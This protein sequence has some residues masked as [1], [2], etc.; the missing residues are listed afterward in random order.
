MGRWIGAGRPVSSS[1]RTP[2]DAD[3][4]RTMGAGAGAGAAGLCS[5]SERRDGALD[6][7]LDCALGC[8]ANR[9]EAGGGEEAAGAPYDDRSAAGAP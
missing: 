8:A 1:P 3:G 5:R 7:A 9:D 2:A 4:G 6:C